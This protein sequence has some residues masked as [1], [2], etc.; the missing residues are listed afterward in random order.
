MKTCDD[1]LTR[2]CIINYNTTKKIDLCPC[3]TC[4]IKMSCLKQCT[5]FI[6]FFHSVFG[7][8]SVTNYKKYRFN[9]EFIRLEGHKP[10][11]YT[12]REDL[13]TINEPES[14]VIPY[15]LKYMSYT[16]II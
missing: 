4:I 1:C 5:E 16:S 7:I 10:G 11:F 2:N 3:H 15:R 6:E 13:N 8:D 9:S 14:Y 12:I